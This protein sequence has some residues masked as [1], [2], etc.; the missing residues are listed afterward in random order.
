MLNNKIDKYKV[1]IVG[2]CEVPL[3]AFN[4]VKG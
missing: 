2:K 3:N 1:V 4:L